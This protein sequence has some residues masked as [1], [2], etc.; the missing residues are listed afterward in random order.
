M[1]EFSIL[2]IMFLSDHKLLNFLF[3]GPFLNEGGVK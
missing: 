3:T 1:Y 2:I